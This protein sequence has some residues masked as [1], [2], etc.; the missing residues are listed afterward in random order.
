MTGG[1]KLQQ[2]PEA[3]WAGF[4]RCAELLLSHQPGDFLRIYN[5]RAIPG[6]HKVPGVGSQPAE[7]HQLAFHLHGGTAFGRGIRVLPDT[8]PDV[9]ELKRYGQD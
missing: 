2:W 1:V 6:S 5:L 3:E 4:N 7:L 8:C 9:Q